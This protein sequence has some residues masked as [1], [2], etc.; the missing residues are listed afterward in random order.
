[1]HAFGAT[2]I[3]GFGDFI[4][5]LAEVARETG[6]EPGRDIPVRI[7]SGHMGAESRASMSEAWGGAAVYDWYGVGDTG[8]IAGAISGRAL[9]D[10]AIDLK[11]AV[12]ALANGTEG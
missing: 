2:A 5:R 12:A 4:K 6:L 1:M 8:V 11:A 3:V 10:G 9:Y 7:I